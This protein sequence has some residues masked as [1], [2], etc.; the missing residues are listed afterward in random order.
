MQRWKTN[1]IHLFVEENVPSGSDNIEAKNNNVKFDTLR[2][3]QFSKY[4]TGGRGVLL[5]YAETTL[6]RRKT[7]SRS[8][9]RETPRI[10]WSRKDVTLS[11]SHGQTSNLRT[12]SSRLS[13][14]PHHQCHPLIAQ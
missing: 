10:D 14:E 13:Q 6:A 11:R 5:P 9:Y 2:L 8:I 3:R 4:L 12:T 7:K 1:L